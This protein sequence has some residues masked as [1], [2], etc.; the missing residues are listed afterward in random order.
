[1]PDQPAWPSC[2]ASHHRLARRGPRSAR[3][4]QMH[5]RYV[6]FFGA[7]DVCTT[8]MP[9]ALRTWFRARRTSFHA[10]GLWPGARE[11]SFCAACLGAPALLA[12]LRAHRIRFHSSCAR[13]TARRTSPPADVSSRSAD[14]QCPSARVTCLCAACLREAN[15]R[16]ES[17]GWARRCHCT[18]VMSLCT[19][20][21][22]IC[23]RV[24]PLS[25]DVL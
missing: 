13:V 11:R 16:P 5:E 25:T 24:E 15:S 14:V 7:P 6:A 17:A 3:G 12:S 23:R 2:G 4:V 22:L 9:V 8:D 21:E 1:V 10:H 18:T 19:C 20:A